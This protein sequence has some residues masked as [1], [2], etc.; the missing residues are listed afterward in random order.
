VRCVVRLIDHEDAPLDAVSY[1]P[2]R[3]LIVS[4]SG[5]F[6]LFV[7]VTFVTLGVF[8]AAPATH[9]LVTQPTV[10]AGVGTLI[11]ALFCVFIAAQIR[12]IRRDGDQVVV[13]A[14]FEQRTVSSR[15]SVL[16]VRVSYGAR[17]GT[18][19]IVY[20]RDAGRRADLAE[21]WAVGPADRAVARLE[22]A[23]FDA[24][25][26]DDPARAEGRSYVDGQ[27]RQ[28]EGAAATARAQVDAYYRSPVWRRMPY[29]I[30]GLL[31]LYLVAVGLYQ[32]LATP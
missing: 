32:W 4:R 20:A 21:Y 5:R 12:F 25:D 16:G 6:A 15:A 22:R 17:G 9:S 10:K 26:V 18:N 13:R 19:Y 2:Q 24:A 11:A 1:A 3:V 30:A 28:W 27:R 31:A 8:A 7:P 14:L 29:V 23:L